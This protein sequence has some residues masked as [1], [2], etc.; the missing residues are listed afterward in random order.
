VAREHTLRAIGAFLG[1]V[2][3]VFAW[4]APAAA[5]VAL[6]RSFPVAGANLSTM[7]TQVTLIFDD[8]LD[9]DLSS[10]TVTGPGPTD[11]GT[12][13]VDLTVPDR[14]VMNTGVIITVPGIYTVTYTVA[15]VDGHRVEGSFSFGYRATTAIPD[16]TSEEGPDTAMSSPQP[17]FELILFGSAFLLASATVALRRRGH[18]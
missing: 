9:P 15:G 17:R 6:V 12:G 8:E 4:A 18:R 11:D 14:N 13:Y 7:P 2:L 5:H 3:A 16:P 1:A 10:F